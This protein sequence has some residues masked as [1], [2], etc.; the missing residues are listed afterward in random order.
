MRDFSDSV[1]TDDAVD[2][3]VNQWLVALATADASPR[4][5]PAIHARP[6]AAGRVCRPYLQAAGGGYRVSGCH[7]GNS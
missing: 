5:E 3:A 1:P 6:P 4:R 2:A 7:G